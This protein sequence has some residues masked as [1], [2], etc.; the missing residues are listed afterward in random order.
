MK[1]AVIDLFPALAA[2][3]K[4]EYDQFCSEMEYTHST[5][6]DVS[7]E[8]GSKFARIVVADPSRSTRGFVA[9]VDG[10]FKN[11]KPFTAGTLLKAAG[12]KAPA[13]NFARGSIFTLDDPETL[14]HVR[15]TGIG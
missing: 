10:V 13:L 2:A 6:Y 8:E 4:A 9:L 3:L 5:Q 14:K 7:F 1:Q 11:K 12:W 15:W